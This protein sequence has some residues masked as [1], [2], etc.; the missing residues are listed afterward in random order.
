MWAFLERLLDSS[1]FSPHGICLLWEPE[2]IWLHVVSD[3]VIA[4][5]YFSI[6]FALA[7]VVS[8]RRDFQ[9]GWIGRSF[10]AFIMACGL[11]HIFSIYTLWVPVY[12]IEGIVKA[13]TAIASIVTAV[14]LWPLIPKIIAI[15]SSAQLR[16]AY[17]ALEEEGKQRRGAETLLQRFRETEATE[18]QIRQAQKMEAVGQLTGGIAHDFNNILTVITGTIE[19]LADAVA[20]RPEL[21]GIAKLI[22]DAASRGAALTQHLLAFA[23]KQHCNRPASTSTP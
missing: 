12:G 21:A 7:I 16:Q 9:F 23:R 18:M 14:I 4:A 2:L 22:D 3:A 11:T 6:P 17:V 15:P 10:A 13:I 1:M 5:S 20:D 8:K 19:I